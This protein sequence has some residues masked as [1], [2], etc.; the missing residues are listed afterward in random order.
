MKSSLRFL[1]AASLLAAVS[2]QAAIIRVVEKS[3]TVQPRGTLH[4][5][6]SRVEIRVQPANDNVAKVPARQKIRASSAADADELLRKLD[7]KIEQTGVL[8]VSS[9][10]PRRVMFWWVARGIRWE[11]PYY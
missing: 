7:L 1:L 2:V 3:F 9:L 5:E 6:T 8:P 11:P 4:V 10:R